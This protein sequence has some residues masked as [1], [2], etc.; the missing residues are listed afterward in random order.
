M[1][2]EFDSRANQSPT[3]TIDAFPGLP[4]TKMHLPGAPNELLLLPY[5]YL[6]AGVAALVNHWLI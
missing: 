3:K 1:D 2:S 6:Q 4:A 5:H